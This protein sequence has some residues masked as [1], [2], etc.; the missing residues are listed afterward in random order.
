VP[1]EL[2]DTSACA[3]GDQIR[4]LWMGQVEALGEV[5]LDFHGVK[6]LLRLI[7]RDSE[8]SAAALAYARSEIHKMERGHQVT[9][10]WLRE[11]LP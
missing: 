6:E 4:A 2:A 5:L 3:K 9:R 10:E 7:D 11:I 1:I 8:Y